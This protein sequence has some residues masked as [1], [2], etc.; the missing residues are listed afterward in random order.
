MSQIFTDLFHLGGFEFYV[1][2][3]LGTP[4][5]GV[6]HVRAKPLEYLHHI[7]IREHLIEFSE[8]PNGR[9]RLENARGEAGVLTVDDTTRTYAFLFVAAVQVGSRRCCLSAL[10]VRRCCFT[11]AIRIFFGGGIYIVGRIFQQG[12]RSA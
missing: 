5:I 9:K 6:V 2:G 8:W 7:G 10:L 1:V 11:R 12:F 4:L 3:I